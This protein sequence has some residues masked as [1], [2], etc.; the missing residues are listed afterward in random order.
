MLTV[1]SEYAPPATLRKK[2]AR[3]CPCLA[4][5]ATEAN[6]VCT[7]LSSAPPT[8][9][10]APG[11]DGM[12]VAPPPPRPEPFVPPLPLTLA[13]LVF[14][15]PFCWVGAFPWPP[16]PLLLGQ[17]AMAVSAVIGA[18]PMSI[19]RKSDSF[20]FPLSIISWQETCWLWFGM[21]LG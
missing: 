19:L 16:W 17:L 2:L 8:S 9:P 3:F 12:L 20:N 10:S 11:K 15:V 6:M 14:W 13:T 18:A 21:I 5:I 4:L 7:R 1:S